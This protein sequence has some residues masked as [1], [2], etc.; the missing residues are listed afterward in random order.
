MFGDTIICRE[1]TKADLPAVLRLYGQP[2]FDDGDVLTLNVAEQIYARMI[3]YP[4]YKIYVATHAD[5]IVGTFALL[6]MDNLGH[7]GTPSAILEDVAV[8]P[9]WQNLGIGKLMMKYALELC[10]E[11]GCYK[12]VLSSNLKRDRAH[13]F[14][15]SLGFERHGY[16]YRIGISEVTRLTDSATVRPIEPK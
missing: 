12:A 1:I 4:D 13:A 10:A 15:E 5:S 9:A 11:K 3:S 14:Y 16:S 8:D 6:I 2:K 7:M